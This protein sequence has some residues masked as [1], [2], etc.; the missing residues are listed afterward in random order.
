LIIRPDNVDNEQVGALYITGENNN[1]Q[2]FKTSDMDVILTSI[3]ATSSNVTSA[4]IFQVPNQPITFAGNEEATELGEDGLIA[5]TWMDY[6]RNPSR[7]D[8]LAT[9]P[10]VKTAVA[11]MDAITE[12]SAKKVSDGD[13]RKTITY[14]YLAGASKRG[15]TTWLTAA[16]EGSKPADQRRVIGAAPIVYDSLNMTHTIPRMY[17]LLG[18]WS[19]AFQPYARWNVTHLI[20]TP[21]FD[22]LTAA[23]DPMDSAY[24]PGLANIDKLVLNTLGDEFFFPNNDQLWW[25]SLP[26]LKHRYLAPNAEHTTITGITGIFGS[27]AAH[28]NAIL[29]N[30]V[31]PTLNWSFSPTGTLIATSDQQP[32]SVKIYRAQTIASEPNRRDFRLIKANVEG[33]CLAPAFAVSDKLCFNPVWWDGKP[34]EG[35][36]NP[37]THTYVYQYHETLSPDFK[38]WVG[39]VFMFE[40]PDGQTYTTQAA[41]YPDTLPFAPCGSGEACYG[42]FV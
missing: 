9:F 25:N 23:I 10:M 30:K 14:F 36:Y 17:E 12:Y 15:C 29:A 24:L 8:Y 39:L 19:F 7:P 20:G 31:K 26:G 21:A 18:G 42:P 37:N 27:I 2:S 41:F 28:L 34:V 35:T 4:A 11:A 38:D 3:L 40:Y 1:K 13:W 16:F 33:G 6:V 32:K 22:F 5:Y